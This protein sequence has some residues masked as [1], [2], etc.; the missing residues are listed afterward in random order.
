MID[1]RMQAVKMWEALA[2]QRQRHMRL[3][4]SAAEE[5]AAKRLKV[6]DE[7]MK[8]IRG[9]NWELH[10]RIRNLQMQA[11][12]WQ[13]LAASNEAAANVL[14]ANLQR[15][16]D[17]Q[18][19]RGRGVRDVDDAGSCCWGEDHEEFCGD[20]DEYEV[21]KPVAMASVGS[22]KGCRQ[23]A[24]VVLLLPCRHLCV[25]ASCA[26]TVGACPACGCARTGTICVNFS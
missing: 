8:C 18:A 9:M 2:K 4:T 21:S 3:I 16:L 22:C 6:K 7:E 13:E 23:G 25:C 1:R 12:M 24:A 19:V 17:A 10:G 11:R 26:N 14:R 15:A 5:R 20:D